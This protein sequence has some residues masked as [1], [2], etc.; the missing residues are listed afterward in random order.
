MLAYD[1]NFRPIAKPWWMANGKIR[2]PI[3]CCSSQCPCAVD[4]KEYFDRL[5]PGLG[6]NTSLSGETDAPF[7]R[8]KVD[9]STRADESSQGIVVT[10]RPKVS[11]NA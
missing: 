1:A 5:N 4:A 7:G 6:Y 10:T 3:A 8:A 2:V 11:C 9:I